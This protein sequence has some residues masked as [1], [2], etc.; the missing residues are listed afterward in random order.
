[1][2]KRIAAWLLQQDLS[3][4]SRAPNRSETRCTAVA[5]DA[6][7]LLEPLHLLSAAQP[8]EAAPT[9][10]LRLGSGAL[11]LGTAM[12]LLAS[13]LPD[14]ARAAIEQ[15]VTALHIRPDKLRAHQRILHETHQ[16]GVAA[17]T[18][19]DGHAKRIYLM[20]DASQISTKCGTIWHG[21]PRPITAD[22]R[23]AILAAASAMAGDE[24]RVIAYATAAGTDAPVFLGLIALGEG[25]R[26][27]AMA[28]V[29]ALQSLGHVVRLHAQGPMA[30][31]LPLLQKRTGLAACDGTER[32]LIT[33]A[34]Q[35]TTDALVITAPVGSAFAA[36][37]M[38]LHARC[39]VL[40]SRGRLLGLLTA[41]AMAGSLISR[42][43]WAMAAALLA[44]LINA[45]ILV[46]APPRRE[47]PPPVICAL[48]PLLLLGA[49]F[50]FLRA[51]QPGYAIPCAGLISICMTAAFTLRMRVRR[52][53]WWLPLMPS[54]LAIPCVMAL[55][56]APLT[57]LFGLL[58]GALAAAVH[59]AR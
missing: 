12:T 59:L 37:L 18:V 40:R 10:S 1:M 51:A 14:E 20:G 43:P 7:C 15:A 6:A 36:P 23:T 8:L 45:L 25:V 57:L 5:L 39:Q 26:A 2:D 38:Q 33:P 34:P 54:L 32:I 27:D 55:L 29:K 11:L 35:G 50:H 44:G 47:G 9:L 24:G 49:A 42:S 19:Q 46:D 48:L 22:D 56:P 17:L 4:F 13:A 30:D 41:L 52:K 28:E 53:R 21:S 58:L 31:R 3:D 16:D